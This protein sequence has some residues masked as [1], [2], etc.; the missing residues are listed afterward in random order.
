VKLLDIY[1]SGALLTM[2]TMALVA[3]KLQQMHG[4]R[5]MTTVLLTLTAG[6]IWPVLTFASLQVLAFLV[7]ANGVHAL[8]PRSSHAARLAID[9]ALVGL[10]EAA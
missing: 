9:P 3:V 8:R 5:P 1:L 6:A 10:A 4:M 7:F 2:V